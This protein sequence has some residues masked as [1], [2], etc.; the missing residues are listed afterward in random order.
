MIA[1]VVPVKSLEAP[2]SR[3]R[4]RLG[5]EGVRALTLA[6]LEDV[7]ETLLAVPQ[8]SRVAVVTPDPAVA[9]R[10]RRAGADALLRD[11]PG[12]NAA[13]EA[14]AGTLAPGPGDALLT[15]LGDVAGACPEDLGRLLAAAPPGRAVV[16]APSRD[17]GTA[18][19]LRRPKD[20]IPAG[21]GPSS[22]KV[23][24]DLAERARVPFVE[25]PLASLALDL[26]EPEDLA[27]FA[28]Q[29]GGGARTRA[30]LATLEA[31]QR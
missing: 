23:H 31:P 26:D 13:V 22:A 4:P 12:L 21:F 9:A 3:L 5:S 29:A 11:D 19:L 20:V 24:R 28:A 17:G 27:S 30:L 10:A 6:M 14:A 15:V 7:L 8:L 18:A 25:L 2:K 1:A 16:L